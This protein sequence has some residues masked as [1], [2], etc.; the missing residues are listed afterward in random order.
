MGGVWWQVSRQACPHCHYGK[1][2]Q[3]NGDQ[4]QAVVAGEQHD[5]NIGVACHSSVYA[6]PPQNV[7]A[8]HPPNIKVAMAE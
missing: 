5:T 8:L 7:Y 6:R 4:R 2:T 3:K 1:G